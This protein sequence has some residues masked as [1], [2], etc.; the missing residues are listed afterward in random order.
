MT[1]NVITCSLGNCGLQT[2][3]INQ[4][5]VNILQ[6]IEH[7]RAC[8]FTPAAMEVEYEALS[9]TVF[10]VDFAFTLTGRHVKYPLSPSARATALT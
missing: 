4:Q 2:E 3:Q 10:R 1:A 8:S 7:S 5:K 9:M 6:S